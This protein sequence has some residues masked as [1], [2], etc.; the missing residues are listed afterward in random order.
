MQGDLGHFKLSALLPLQL[1]PSNAGGGS[2]Q[3]L[4]HSWAE[5]EPHVAEQ[6]P[7]GPQFSQAPLTRR[8]NIIGR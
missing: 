7:H 1:R 2:T 4:V 5:V 8:K 6:C 3:C